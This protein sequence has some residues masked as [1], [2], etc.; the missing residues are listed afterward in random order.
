MTMMRNAMACGVAVMA[1][2]APTAASAQQRSFNL[3]AQPARIAIPEFARQAAIQI[4]APA[5][6]LDGVTTPAVNGQKDV[7]AALAQ[8]LEGSGLEV[9]SDSG[10]VIVL[11][12]TTTAGVDQGQGGDIVVTG[13][14]L[15]GA[16]T[17]TPNP[18]AQLAADSAV[19]RSGSISIGDQLS[20]LPQFRTTAT[21]A[22]S[23]GLGTQAPGQVGL[24]LLDLRGLGTTRTLVLQNGRRL[25][26]ST[27]QISQPD[28]NTIPTELLSRVDILTGGASAVYGADAIAGVVNF[29]LKDDYEGL[30][31]HA[32]AGISDEG[33]AGAQQI[34]LVAGRNL[35]DGR[36]NIA[37]A[38]E[39]ARRDGLRYS[40]R[41]FA[42]GQSDFIQ[43]PNAGQ[44]GQPLTIPIND[45]RYLVYSNGG[46]LPYGAPYYRFQPNGSLAPANTGSVSYPN[47]G[48]SD[49]GDG[50]GPIDTGSLLPDNERVSAT[51]LGHFDISDGATL[52]GQFD[53]IWQRASAFNGPAIETFNFAKT[54][55]FLGAQALSVI[56]AYGPTAATPSFVALRA[57]T[58]LGIFGE[59]DTRKTVRG[60]VGVKGRLSDHLRYELSYSYGRT[61]IETDFFNNV[62]RPR[63]Q[64][65]AN[66]VRDIAGV[67][68]TPGAI[69]CAARLAAPTSTNPDIA[70][71][72]PANYFGEGSISAAARNYITLTTT[73]N[74]LIQQHLAGGFLAGDT[75]GFLTLPGG[76]PSFVIG[77]EFRRESTRYVPD[78][79]D[80]TGT[81]LASGDR[82][83]GA[84]EVTEGY[85]ELKLPI[86][87]DVPGIHRLE[88]SLSG[89]LS[90]YNLARV[91]TKGSWGVG[92]LYQPV[93]DIG[94]RGSYQRAVRAPN[95]A[96][97]FQPVLNGQTQIT[98]PCD[99]RF[100]AQGTTT[101]KANCAAL[102]I[103]AN[104]QT[105]TIP[106]TVATTTSGNANLDVER[107]TTY[108]FGAILTPRFLPRFT[109]SADYYNVTLRGAIAGVNST[110]ISP[111]RV[112]SQCV[113][114]PTLQNPFCALVQRDAA[115]N[116]VRVTQ[117]PI[118]L[119]RLTASGIDVDARY[120]IPL[121]GSNRID[122]RGL[123]SYV[124]DRDD[125]R[126]PA[127]PDF[128]T[129]IVDTPSNPR[130]QTVFATTLKL[131]A[132][133][134]GH[135]FRYFSSVFYKNDDVA[136]FES[137]NG[138]P[139]LNPNRRA[140]NFIKTGAYSYHDLRLGVDFGQGGS[141]Y[142][143]VD[144]VADKKPPFSIYGAG[145]GG[146]QFDSVG[147]FF[148]AGIRVAM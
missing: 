67:L 130:F 107:G 23:T 101:R 51:L 37:L 55:P 2:V 52:F 4:V 17:L 78:P 27:Q 132:V 129:Q 87:A 93:P 58:D 118:N 22:A 139:P 127:Q 125:Y 46:T 26:S 15:A 50:L 128:R 54:N 124:I 28:T 18:V 80:T 102:G 143:G 1:L 62:S 96:E 19:T 59:R 111:F 40:D 108:T 112:P 72:V 126:A 75:G 74:G 3:P 39:Y 24:N 116:I 13:S 144:N 47:L 43:N 63:A 148:Y 64:L 119:T 100:I 90:H 81:T 140:A 44:A 29:V 114:A 89:R 53:G 70:G 76:A 45:I 6:Q 48:I 113:D 97:L 135:K 61:E 57:L 105:A 30:S 138:V 98:D 66:A 110:T 146:A 69:V 5:D 109:L 82:A 136:F 117:F 25:V 16:A 42:R 7:R 32:Q 121:G 83:G 147:R 31:L 104:F 41:D 88:L 73:S 20:L 8:L 115:N 34:G 99:V 92:A 49:G 60:V 9:A 133:E 10:G 120:M 38:L 33:D 145:F 56:N 79:R 91:G 12:R 77:A 35:S 137:V 68:G 123:A 141:F 21:Q 95:I 103:P 134:L 122:L 94:F 106:I 142:L 85:G 84:V 65:A 14:R 71:C 131:G 36:G 86:A 11:R